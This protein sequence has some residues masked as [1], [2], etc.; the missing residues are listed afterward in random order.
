MAQGYEIKVTLENVK[1]DSV[2]LQTFV[3]KEF[4]NTH[5]LPYSNEVLFKSKT[6][7]EPGIYQICGD[8][9][10]LVTFFISDKKS[11]KFSIHYENNE[12]KVTYT[13]SPE[14][15]AFEEYL[16]GL[17]NI[18]KKIEVLNQE[19]EEMRN[20]AK[21]LPLIQPGSPHP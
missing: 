15:I 20:S 19:F 6:S 3:K 21:R 17:Q 12:S 14:N 1:C 8:T 11:Q 10:L 9:N 4:K 16:I 2:H 7:L 13:N 18:N 5:S